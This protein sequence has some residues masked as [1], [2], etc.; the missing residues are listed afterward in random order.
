MFRTD[1]KPGGVSP[2]GKQISFL[3]FDDI[4]IKG[5][6]LYAEGKEVKGT[7]ILLHGIR[8][9]KECYTTVSKK[10][11]V[12]GYHTVAIDLRGHGESGGKYCTFGIKEKQ[13]VSALIDY[14]NQEEGITDHIGVWGRSLGGAVALQAMAVDRRIVFG[15]VESTFS[16][17]RKIIGDYSRYYLNFDLKPLTAYLVNRA[18][19]I[20]DF[21]PSKART[22]EY[23]KQIQQP[24]FFAHGDAD[25]QINIENGRINFTA[26]ASTDKEFTTIE[27][28]GHLNVWELGGGA[29]FQ[30]V[31]GF[32]S[33]KLVDQP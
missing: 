19:A 7:I 32:I 26:L 1:R 23:C 4:P 22:V 5:N 6:L 31:L 18:G 33:R 25:Q 28:A 27:G 24:V 3:S 2:V 13:D 14:L 12:A 8:S 30:K 9:G 15:V 29:Y 10:L 16:D 21:D 17:F 20:G 11:S